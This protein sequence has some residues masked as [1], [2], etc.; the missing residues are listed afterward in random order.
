[1]R[2]IH[3]RGI[4]VQRAAVQSRLGTHPLVARYW[5]A[6]ESS[7]GATVATLVDHDLGSASPTSDRATPSR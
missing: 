2:L 3:G 4:G 5:D 6:P 1:M 7:G